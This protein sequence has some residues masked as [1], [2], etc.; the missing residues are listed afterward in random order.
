[1]VKKKK[2]MCAAMP[3]KTERVERLSFVRCEYNNIRRTFNCD[4]RFCKRWRRT[5]YVKHLRNTR[6]RDTFRRA[7]LRYSSAHSSKLPLAKV[8]YTLTAGF[9]SRV[10]RILSAIYASRIFSQLSVN[11]LLVRYAICGKAAQLSVGK[12]ERQLCVH[13]KFGTAA[14][15]PPFPSYL[16]TFSRFFFL[17]HLYPTVSLSS[18]TFASR[19]SRW[20]SPRLRH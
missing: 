11:V 4:V 19:F 20:R 2:R 17:L 1:M 12:S 16:L 18:T 15:V 5:A 13:S 6:W 14:R 8:R 7:G 3:A 9:R 10:S